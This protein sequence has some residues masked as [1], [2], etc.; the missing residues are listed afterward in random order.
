MSAMDQ[1][2]QYKQQLETDLVRVEAQIADMELKFFQADHSATGSVIKGFEA[3]LSSKEALRKRLQRSWRTEDR[4]FS[5]SSCTSPVTKE[6]QEQ[7]EAEPALQGGFGKKGYPPAKGY[8][9]KGK[10]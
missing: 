2:L 8:P 3:H 1:L 6:L 10:R 4:W 9:Q 7:Q 5:L